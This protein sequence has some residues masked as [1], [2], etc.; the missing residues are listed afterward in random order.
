MRPLWLVFLALASALPI[1]TAAAQRCAFSAERTATVSLAGL[2]H[3]R[4]AARAG[5]L[6]IEGRPG[7]QEIRARGS[8]CASSRRLLD[9]I[10]FDAGRDGTEARLLVET[11]E[12]NGGGNQY[13]SLDLVI[14]VPESLGLHVSDSSG[15]LEIRRVGGLT[16]DDSSGE[17]EIEDVRGSID[18][19]DSSGNVEIEGVRGDVRLKDSSGNLNVRDVT[20]SVL[21]ESDSSGDI[22]LSGISGDAEVGTDSSGDISVTRVRGDFTVRRDGSGGIRYREIAGR[23]Q[24]PDR[25]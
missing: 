3:A 16:L 18:L 24:I 14:E 11:P 17:I 7:L 20:G 21:V 1:S 13:A 15:D 4:I 25:D 8:A 19:T 9:E 5:S 10:R 12:M 6:R 22:E 2:Q 23:V